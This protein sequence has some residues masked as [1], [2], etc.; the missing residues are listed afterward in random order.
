[1]DRND[2]DKF[3]R[4]ADEKEVP[5]EASSTNEYLGDGLDIVKPKCKPESRPEK[6]IQFVRKLLRKRTKVIRKRI[7]SESDE[8]ASNEKVKQLILN[9]AKCLRAAQHQHVIGFIDA[10]FC[11]RPNPHVAIIME[12]ATGTLQDFMNGKGLWSAEDRKTKLAR[13]FGCLPSVVAYI[14]GI[15]LRH[16]DIKP[17]NILFN[18]DV[19]LLADF[20]ISKLDL[21]KTLS[22]TKPQFKSSTM[23]YAAPEVSATGGSRGQMADI[24]SL[25]AV[26]L[27]MLAFYSNRKVL[28]NAVRP[29]QPSNPP[30]TNEETEALSSYSS[31]LSEVQQWMQDWEEDL[32]PDASIETRE[33]LNLCQKMLVT[34]RNERP[35]AE[36][37]DQKIQT[38]GSM[39][40]T[41]PHG[42]RCQMKPLTTTQILFDACR[43][44]VD[45]E[46][47][48]LLGQPEYSSMS[49]GLIAAFH[50]AAACGHDSI[51]KHF[52]EC[53]GND[54]TFK[55]ANRGGYSQQTALHCAAGYG[56]T[57]VIRTLLNTGVVKV[58]LIDLDEK[59]ALHC[60]AG[61]DGEGEVVELLLKHNADVVR[62]DEEQRTA[63]HYAASR[64][65]TK[66]ARLIINALN[67]SG[68]NLE[69]EINKRDIYGGT[70]LHLAAGFGC[71][72]FVE[73]L[74]GSRADVGI[75]DKKNS[76]ALHFACRG[77]RPNVE[78]DYLRIINLLKEYGVD[79]NQC[80]EAKK[81]AHDYAVQG[82]HGSRAEAL[83]AN[84]GPITTG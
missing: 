79:V 3:V 9:E 19:L 56:R 12:K 45:N 42:C 35:S 53:F 83:E 60:A 33:I 55:I 65:R 77:T 73:L 15:G 31:Q 6:P 36:D 74:L 20:G 41:V 63:L 66:A 8:V 57:S 7:K 58:N 28:S 47:R 32:S 30:E 37:I 34:D 72:E 25:G 51:V 61:N 5:Y 18:G 46:V 54:S 70:A 64:G 2:W 81:T 21:G 44:G 69:D 75:L 27:E 38:F 10:Y 24:F 82:A 29:E 40:V 17:Q 62:A 11:D 49:P 67:V 23:K 39:E 59:T 80:D 50:K 1:M 84:E 4:Y 22:T 52:L 16:R 13:W 76:T 43:R 71:A 48:E 26:L 14:H 68:C 78:D